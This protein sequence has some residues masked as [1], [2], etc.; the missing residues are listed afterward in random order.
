MESGGTYRQSMCSTSSAP[1]GSVDLVFE[2]L[3][4]NR[5]VQEMVFSYLPIGDLLTCERVSRWFRLA[6]L[7]HGWPS[8][9]HLVVAIDRKKP[10]INRQRI[11]ERNLQN[12]IKCIIENKIRHRL[13]RLTIRYVRYY[14]KI[15]N[16][17]EVDIKQF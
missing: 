12:A 6:A 16:F 4:A 7:D 13:K 2:T 14:W 1:S 5:I 10:S 9:S 11:A 8:I 3:R 15:A 17:S